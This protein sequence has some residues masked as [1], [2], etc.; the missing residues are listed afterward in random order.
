M[1]DMFSWVNSF[2]TFA[3]ALLTLALVFYTRALASAASFA[4]VV[5]SIE[6]HPPGPVL[7]DLV[8]HNT[9]NATAFDVEVTLSP[10]P[11]GEIIEEGGK[12]GLKRISVVRPYQQCRTL[13]ARWSEVRHIEFK[14]TVKWKPAQSS[15][16]YQIRHY[17]LPM[18][19][20]E[21]LSLSAYED[22]Q[23]HIA[24]YIKSIRDDVNKFA[25]GTAKLKIVNQADS[26][27][28][29]PEEV[30]QLRKFIEEN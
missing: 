3:L 13:I 28:L 4:E 7:L 10:E 21:H 9:G 29:S 22:K 11:I 27:N 23:Y 15:K 8:I 5:V 26:E 18:R 25:K 30:A 19:H 17:T 6:P 12:R 1:N 24:N 14:A 2:S 16:R 20:F